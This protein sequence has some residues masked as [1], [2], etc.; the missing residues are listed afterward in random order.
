MSITTNLSPETIKAKAAGTITGAQKPKDWPDKVHPVSQWL[1]G[2]Q[3]HRKDLLGMSPVCGIAFVTSEHKLKILQA[4][5]VT[6]QIDDDG[7]PQDSYIVG[8]VGN[9]PTLPQPAS[10]PMKEL[11]KDFWSYVQVDETTQFEWEKMAKKPIQEWTPKENETAIQLPTAWTTT[12]VARFPVAFPLVY[13]HKL[14]AGSLTNPL[15][16]KSVVDY[17]PSLRSWLHAIDLQIASNK[18]LPDLHHLGKAFL[19]KL[20]TNVEIA[21]GGFATSNATTLSRDDE[22]EKDRYDLV[23][24]K[25]QEIRSSNEA[26]Y[27]RKHPEHQLELLPTNMRP[28]TITTGNPQFTGGDEEKSQHTSTHQDESAPSKLFETAKVL[29][30]LEGARLEKDANGNTVV[31]YPEIS[32]DW[33]DLY[34]I[35]HV[36]QL[37][38]AMTSLLDAACEDREN[39][40]HY[41]DRAINLP[42]FSQLAAKSLTQAISKR[43]P[44]DDDIKFRKNEISILTV[45]PPPTAQGSESAAA[46]EQYC[47]STHATELDHLVGQTEKQQ[48]KVGTE[49]FTGGKQNHP[50]DV[51]AAIANMDVILMVKYAYNPNDEPTMPL[52]AKLNRGLADLYSSRVFRNWYAKVSPTAPWITHTLLTQVHSLFSMVAG[53]ANNPTNRRTFK[54]GIALDP[55]IYSKVVLE[56]NR[57]YD[58]TMATISSSSLG[59]LF[60]SP[61]SS[62]HAK[63]S[64]S[65]N[66]NKRRNEHEAQPNDRINKSPAMG[67]NK[68]WLTNTTGRHV[69]VPGVQFCSAFACDSGPCRYN[70]CT[71]GHKNF[72][73]DFDKTEQGQICNHVKSTHGLQF[74]SH[75]SLPHF[76]NGPGIGG[77]PG[78]SAQAKPSTTS[79]PANSTKETSASPAV[80]S[81]SSSNDNVATVTP[82]KG[83]GQ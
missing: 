56:Y 35:G 4:T 39:N 45:L 30:K 48:A 6:Y 7:M 31:V 49:I 26:N 62:Y 67:N 41:L 9:S 13:G 58:N 28:T 78:R 50:D 55:A 79:S 63:K 12:H 81:K 54:R 27:F 19:P 33:E 38:S 1:L 70:A 61:P 83:A 25:L 21:K 17:H 73:R 36:A 29:L 40:T 43:T 60:T 47:R 77:N 80:A 82:S 5:Q 44:L 57:I 34:E 65:N 74:A 68:G 37:G 15:I 72:P 10:L 76:M 8:Q 2:G 64:T 14:R 71:R 53:I 59:S 20:P 69:H 51:V 3:Q 66:N 18:P 11:L 52:I 46:Y 24:Q 16:K 75:I 32:E 42:D 23:T 22:D